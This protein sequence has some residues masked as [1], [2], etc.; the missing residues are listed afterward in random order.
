[1]KPQ[2]KA[3]LLSGLVFPG[4]GYL[5]LKCYY[6]GVVIVVLTGISLFGL[7]QI[8]LMKTQI[9]MDQMIAGEVSQDLLSMLAAME[10]ISQI[11]MGWQ[12]YAGYSLLVCWLVS[13]V[14]GYRVG[15]RIGQQ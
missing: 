9:L 2:Y 8:T 4:V 6:R 14:D 11:S 5:P 1:M 7:I 3:A 10:H 15:K 12:D 13:I